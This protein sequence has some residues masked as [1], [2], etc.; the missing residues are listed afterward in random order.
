MAT[1]Y[2]NVSGGSRSGSAQ[3]LWGSPLLRHAVL[4]DDD[5]ISVVDVVQHML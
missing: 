4:A 1:A 3:L 2:P 5:P